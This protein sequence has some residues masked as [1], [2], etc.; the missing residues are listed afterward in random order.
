MKVASTH[1]GAITLTENK[2]LNSLVI[3]TI[4]YR[5][6]TADSEEEIDCHVRMSHDENSS[7]AASG[8]NLL[9]FFS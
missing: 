4:T 8:V 1:N 5:L 6:S 3:D 7:L 9:N 2:F